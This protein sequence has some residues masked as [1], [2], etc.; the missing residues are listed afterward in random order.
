MGDEQNPP[1]QEA[2]TEASGEN[3][4]PKKPKQDGSQG[5]TA[6]P[7]AGMIEIDI[8]DEEPAAPI[9]SVRKHQQ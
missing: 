5:K 8:H 3:S 7:S 1:G 4:T 2:S 9:V 6:K